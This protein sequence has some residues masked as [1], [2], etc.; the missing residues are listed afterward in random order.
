MRRVARLVFLIDVMLPYSHTPIVEIPLAGEVRLLIKREDQ[1][2]PTVSGNKW[3]KLKYNLEQAREKGHTTLLTF[4][5]AYS[6]HIYATAAAAQQ[7]GFRS[8]GIIR[9]ES[10]GPLNPTLA[11]AQRCGMKLHYVSREAYRQK[12]DAGFIKELREKFGQ[13]YVLP[14]GGSNN[15]AIKGCAEWGTQLV[16]EA[17]FDVL[18]VPVG[19]GATLAGLLT[20]VTITTEVIGFSTLKAGTFLQQ[21]VER[22][23]AGC[24]CTSAGPWR[25]ETRY[26]GG[27]YAKASAEL[28]QFIAD[29][30]QRY[31]I[32]LDPV[33]TGK[34]MLG[35]FDMIRRRAF[36]PGTTV[37][38]IHS[39][40]LQGRAG[41][42]LP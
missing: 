41:F 29:F 7:S 1:N 31:H 38:A 18:C 27:G 36:A 21:Q 17:A 33:Y 11:F 32:P 40:G 19:T 37:L 35:I 4:G 28:L 2:H 24:G 25:V 6:N 9:G 42:G 39:G 15:L 10:A 34:M 8:V 22:Q 12:D 5:G 30:E 26:H 20:A 13:A 23:L 16:S 3:W 14:E